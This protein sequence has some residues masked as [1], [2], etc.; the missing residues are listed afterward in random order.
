MLSLFDAKR[1]L[2]FYVFTFYNITPYLCF[3]KNYSYSVSNNNNFTLSKFFFIFERIFI[4]KSV[5]AAQIY[6]Y[7]I[8]FISLILLYNVKIFF[9][10]FYCTFLYFIFIYYLYQENLLYLFIYYK[11]SAVNIQTNF[12]KNN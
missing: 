3:V 7:F 12:D 5:S 2:S 1:F 11:I 4:I 9:F 10:S 6:S 8:F